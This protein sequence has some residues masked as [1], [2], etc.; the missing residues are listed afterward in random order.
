LRNPFIFQTE[1]RLVALTGL[2]ARRLTDLV[3]LMRQ[4]P[5]ACI[6]YHT[7]HMYLAHHFETPVFVNDFSRWCTDALQERS[8]GEKLAAV[9]LLEFSTIRHLRE[10]L[11][12]TMESQLE[13]HGGNSRECPSGEEFHF[14][15]SKSF[16]M[17]TGLVANDPDHLIRLLPRVSNVSL[18]FHFFE[19]RLRLGQ[20][21]ND[22][23]QWLRGHGRDSLAQAIDRLDPYSTSLDGLRQEIIELGRRLN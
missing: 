2:R 18:Y 23:S 20:P 8:L 19:A 9:D 13:S 12:A 10:A 16:I 11:V 5:G 3:E 7:H 17:P 15:K 4:A 21:T 1:R 6:F 14:C 22:F